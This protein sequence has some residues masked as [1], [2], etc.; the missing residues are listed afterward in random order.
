[1]KVIGL[2]AHKNG[3]I[4][5]GDRLPWT[6]KSDMQH[7]RRITDGEV[8]IVGGNTA[9]SLPPLINRTVI[10]VSSKDEPIERADYTVKSPYDA[11]VLASQINK[12][13]RCFVIGGASLLDN[14]TEYLDGLIVSIIKVDLHP[15]AEGSDDLIGLGDTF[16]NWCDSSVESGLFT[17]GYCEGGQK[18][19]D[20]IDFDIYATGV[21]N[22][23]TQDEVEAVLKSKPF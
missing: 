2:Y 12:T 6:C 17:N 1:M 11:V 16:C 15:D 9:R 10:A 23:M 18:L 21:I 22:R 20:M 5:F 19:I 14:M 3:I 7:F 8:L 4:G 13:G